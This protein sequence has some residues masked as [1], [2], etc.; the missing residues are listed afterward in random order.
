[1]FFVICLFNS[2]G[3]AE[4]ATSVIP[5]KREYPVNNSINPCVNFYEYACSSVISG[6][7]LRDD[8]SRHNFAFSDAGE[9]LL[10]FKKKY[11]MDLAQKTPESAMEGEIKNYYSACMN[12]QSRQKEELDLVKQ[13]KE[14]LAKIKTKE[15]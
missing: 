3:Y 4:N 2:L 10:E 8:R 15:E 9:R 12:Q 11:F 6:F 7:K 13:T 1:M 5:D 14:I